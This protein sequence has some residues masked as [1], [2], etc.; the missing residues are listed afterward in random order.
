MSKDEER[1]NNSFDENA[2]G[3]ENY[4]DDLPLVLEIRE[5]YL[6]D[7]F[8]RWTP[9]EVERTREDIVETN[10]NIQPFREELYIC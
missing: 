10:R 2:N 1:T 7:L 4:I 5:R 6:E 8:G 9:E 3:S